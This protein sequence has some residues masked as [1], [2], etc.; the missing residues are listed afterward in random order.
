PMEQPAVSNG[1]KRLVGSIITAVVAAGLGY[2]YVHEGG[3]VNHK[4]D[5]G[6][7][8]RFGIT[9]ATARRYG[10]RGDMRYFPKR[11]DAQH[12]VC[13]DRIYTERYIDGPGYRPL[14]GIEPAVFFEVYDSA[15]LHGPPRSSRWFQEA[16]NELCRSSIAVDGKVGPQTLGAYADC[17]QTI[18]KVTLCLRMLDR[19]DGKQ[20]AFFRA[21]V[22]RRP[23]QKVFLRGWL[24]QRVGN[25]DR[26]K[27]RDWRD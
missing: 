8:T 9:E 6:G 16:I 20:E 5:R 19:L 14:A 10:Y 27:C 26:A 3:Y 25:V 1:R 23:S 13:A 12:P 2:T 7:A 22:A 21:I 15:V 11:C 24:N 18:G 4:A 17:Q